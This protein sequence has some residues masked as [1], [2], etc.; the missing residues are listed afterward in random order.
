MASR[1]ETKKLRLGFSLFFQ[2]PLRRCKSRELRAS[3]LLTNCD[4]I[5]RNGLHDSCPRSECQV[6]LSQK[7][8]VRQ[9]HASFDQGKPC[10]LTKP[11]PLC[12]PAKF[13]MRHKNTTFG[14]KKPPK[15]SDT[16]KPRNQDLFCCQPCEP[17]DP[18]AQQGLC[19]PQ[20]PCYTPASPCEPCGPCFY[21]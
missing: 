1:L 5:K 16:T 18:F 6:S 11:Q 19:C 20:S 10:C 2:N 4:C 7:I 17:F 3:V 21:Y 8:T 12:S 15:C 13:A 14:Q 9:F